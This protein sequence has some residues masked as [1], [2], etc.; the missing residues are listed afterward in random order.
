MVKSKIYNLSFLK[1][2]NNKS[3]KSI[4]LNSIWLLFE[5]VGVLAI[6]LFTNI[7]IARHL[8]VS[9][10]GNLNYAL[11]MVAIFTPLTYLGL[12]SIVIRELVKNPENKDLWL[13]SAFL[14]KIV[15]SVVVFFIFLFFSGFF[16]KD[17]NVVNLATI[18]AASSIFESFGVISF[19]YLSRSKAKYFSLASMFAVLASSLVK[20]LFVVLDKPLIWFGFAAASQVVFLSLLLIVFYRYHQGKIFSWRARY[21]VSLRLLSQSWPLALSS[22][23]ALIYLKIDQVMLGQ[24]HEASELGLYAAAARLSEIW[25]VL[26][27]ALATAVFPTFVKKIESN[28]AEYYSMLE[29]LYRI[30]FFLSLCVVI[31]IAL[32]SEP[33]IGFLYGDT[34]KSAGSILSI[35][36]WAC[37][38][39]FLGAIYAK[40]L[41]VEGLAKYSL[42]RDVIG[43]VINVLLNLYL[44]PLYGGKGAAIATVLAYTIASYIVPFSFKATRRSGILMTKAV[45]YPI[46]FLYFHIKSK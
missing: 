3:A 30:V 15:G 1:I 25:Y 19:W 9:D 40:A 22:V 28:R 13:G 44:I 35:H 39:M 10:F 14:L 12:N 8:G 29:K 46:S 24:M 7:L 2:L 31:P 42:L 26:P 20:V 4:I 45:F 18:L 36:I 6:A 11:A 33:I 37:P 32:I 16:I 27:T 43:G 21:N 41:I 34:F 17:K 5:K 38:A 23:F